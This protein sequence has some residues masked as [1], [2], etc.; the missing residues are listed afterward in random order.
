MRRAVIMG[1]QRRFNN[2]INAGLIPNHFNSPGIKRSH[3]RGFFSYPFLVILGDLE[4]VLNF[5]RIK[6]SSLTAL[7]EK[8]FW[9]AETI[10]KFWIVQYVVAS[11]E[12][13]RNLF[14]TFFLCHENHYW[15]TI[16]SNYTILL[17]SVFGSKFC[18]KIIG[19]F[20]K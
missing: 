16:H 7:G 14:L 4:A 9:V 15:N 19:I 10:H 8:R 20:C 5:S 17:Y 1:N 6:Q 11:I 12:K 3:H 2:I 13:L 18:K